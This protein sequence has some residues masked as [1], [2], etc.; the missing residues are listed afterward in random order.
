MKGRSDPVSGVI[1]EAARSKRAARTWLLHSRLFATRNCLIIELGQ[2]PFVWCRFFNYVVHPEGLR[3]SRVQFYELRCAY[4]SIF[5]DHSL[6][7]DTVFWE[8]HIFCLLDIL[9][10]AVNSC[11]SKHVELLDRKSG[12]LKYW[13]FKSNHY[14]IYDHRCDETLGMYIA[15]II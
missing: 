5:R 10:A 7:F 3:C 2:T 1:Q 6:T 13:L 11:I 9:E 14:K 15:V 8:V 4:C 12:L